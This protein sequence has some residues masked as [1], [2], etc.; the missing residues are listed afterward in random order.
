MG[1]VWNLWVLAHSKTHCFVAGEG[2]AEDFAPKLPGLYR[3]Q[4]LLTA[5]KE[6]VRT[7]EVEMSVLTPV[8]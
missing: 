5:K 7:V 6:N 8:F 1:V 3:L 2:W 4:W